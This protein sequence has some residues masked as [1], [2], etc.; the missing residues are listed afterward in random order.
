LLGELR[1]DVDESS[2]TQGEL[3]LH[4]SVWPTLPDEGRMHELLMGPEPSTTPTSPA[5]A[6][7]QQPS[8]KR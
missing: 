7:S 6:K 4:W 1:R 5:Q 8:T 2:E 3:L